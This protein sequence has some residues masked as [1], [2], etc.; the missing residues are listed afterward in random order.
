MRTG[1]TDPTIR[2]E[3]PGCQ[4]RGSSLGHHDEEVTNLNRPTFPDVVYGGQLYPFDYVEE[5]VAQGIV[6]DTVMGFRTVRRHHQD[7]L[8]RMVVRAA[9]DR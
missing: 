1:D 8:I 6:M 4:D 9:G 7:Q 3:G 2:E 5:A